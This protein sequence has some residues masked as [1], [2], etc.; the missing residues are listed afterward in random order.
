MTIP[1]NY[2][3]DFEA[4]KVYFLNV[5]LK[6]TTDQAPF[7][8]LSSDRW[9]IGTRPDSAVFAN[10]WAEISLPFNTREGGRFAS[11]VGTG[12]GALEVFDGLHN[13]GPN[14]DPIMD[15]FQLYTH[16]ANV[17]RDVVA[18]EGGLFEDDTAAVTWTGG[19][20]ATIDAAAALVGNFGLM[21]DTTGA[22]GDVVVKL[23]LKVGAIQTSGRYVVEFDIQ[24]P[25]AAANS[26]FTIEFETAGG[27]I[28]RT[29]T[30]LWGTGANHVI[31]FLN[32]DIGGT[33]AVDWQNQTDVTVNIVLPV[34]NTTYYIDNVRVY[35]AP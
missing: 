30:T 17:V 7:F 16:N 24:N 34:A 18:N 35:V 1:N 15:N 33:A 12:T 27:K 8:T 20:T 21:V 22:T 26:M 31:D 5:M 29:G 6:N 32:E 3:P 10:E 23:P 13:G 9:G 19:G 28:T 11:N 4:D 2:F 25:T 14:G